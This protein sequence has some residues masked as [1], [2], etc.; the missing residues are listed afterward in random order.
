MS[1]TGPFRTHIGP[2]ILFIV[3][4]HIAYYFCQCTNE[5]QVQAFDLFPKADISH[6]INKIMMGEAISFD[7]E[8]PSNFFS[9]E[10]LTLL[11][12]RVLVLQHPVSA[13]P[14]LPSSALGTSGKGT[15]GQD[16]SKRTTHTNPNM[17]SEL[18]QAIT[19]YINHQQSRLSCHCE[20]DLS[21]SV[22]DTLN[23]HGPVQPPQCAG[24]PRLCHSGL[25]LSR[26]LLSL[27]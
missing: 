1:L 22:Y 14:P 20:Y 25:M 27:S 13:L 6:Q 7:V 15:K 24:L 8:I 12:P 2:S 9:A 21:S 10:A 16:S 4:R 26:W 18:S 23:S 11:C 5:A 17:D 3:H 19:L